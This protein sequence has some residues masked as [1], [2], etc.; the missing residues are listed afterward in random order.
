MKKGVPMGEGKYA[1]HFKW[2][3]LTA[4]ALWGLVAGAAGADAVLIVIDGLNWYRGLSLVFEVVAL[5][6]MLVSRRKLRRSREQYR[7]AIEDLQ[8]SAGA[9]ASAQLLAHTVNFTHLYPGFGAHVTAANLAAAAA[10]LA[11]G[12]GEGAS[13]S[14]EVE[15]GAEWTGGVLRGW[16]QYSLDSLGKLSGGFGIPWDSTE[17]HAECRAAV[18]TPNAVLRTAVEHLAEG[19][20]TCGIYIVGDPPPAWANT[21][22]VY[23]QVVG[24]GAVVEHEHGFR[25]E[26][27]RIE[28]LVVLVNEELVSASV[29]ILVSLLERNYDVPIEVTVKPGFNQLLPQLRAMTAPPPPPGGAMVGLPVGSL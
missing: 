25:V 12:P 17:M 27:C 15:L 1:R 8:R 26:Y 5:G 20:C 24:W 28:R 10:Y 14:V 4:T 16:R 11:A 18:Y 23:A 21:I 9:A 29:E 3:D 2:M 22:E 19:T 7:K 13:P 6:V